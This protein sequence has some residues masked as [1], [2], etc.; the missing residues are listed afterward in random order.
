MKKA[1]SP[2]GVNGQIETFLKENP[3]IKKALKVFDISHSQYESAL[4]ASVSFYTSGSTQ[5][6]NQSI[7]AG[8]AN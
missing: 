5:Q 7:D 3:G 8:K 1:L 4:Q 2:T 6:K